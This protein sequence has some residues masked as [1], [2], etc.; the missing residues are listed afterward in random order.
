MTITGEML[1]GSARVRG[2]EGMFRAIDPSSGKELEPAF[3]EGGPAEVDQACALAWAAFDA[4]RETGFEPR[5]RLLEEI[6][7]RIL[8]I[9]DE[10][11]ERATSETG[12]PRGR[13]E[14]ER[15]R[16]VGQL[17]LFAEVVREGSW[18]EARIDPALPDRTPLPRPDLRL[19]M[20]PLGPVAVF[21]ASNFPLAF[22][23]AGGDTASALAAGCPVVV[24]AHPAHPGTSELVGRAVQ[25]AVADCGLPEGIFS[26]L[27]GAGIEIGGR[28]VA[29]PRIKAVGFTGSRRGGLALME[30]SARRPEPI[31]VFAEMSSINPV[32]ILPAALASRGQEIGKDL[33]GSLTMGAGQFC[34]NPGLLLAQP[35][36]GLDGFVSAASGAI[37][38]GPSAT[39]L[40]SGIFAAYQAGV[41]RLERHPKV[42]ALARGQIGAGGNQGRSVLFA[43]DAETFRSDPV[44]KEEVFGASSLLVRCRDIHDMRSLAEELEGQLTITLQMDPE[45]LDSARIL[46]PTLE[47]KAGRI[48]VNGFPTGVEVAHAMVHGGPFPA[49]SDSRMTS[50]GTLAIRRFLRPVCYQSFPGPL[51]P[52]PVRDGNPLHLWRRIDGK[53]ARE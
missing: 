35:G 18:V 5:A 53:L 2:K 37:T 20:V 41:D 52:E 12:L 31:P 27:F 42:E 7:Q 50:V 8:D 23:V 26:L 38:S 25:A 22:S 49:T 46:L 32:F 47:R 29:D 11:I 21:G 19:R 13:V 16:T 14:G 48:L 28:L 34:T 40:T 6:A 33:V 51:L 9:G 4:F 1:I 44:L 45:D 30:I 3:G 43:T 39:M 36:Q 10:L 24:K 15:A 17:R